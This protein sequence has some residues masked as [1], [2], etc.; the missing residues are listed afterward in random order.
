MMKNLM[1]LEPPNKASVAIQIAIKCLIQFLREANVP[2]ESILVPIKYISTLLEKTSSIKVIDNTNLKVKSKSYFECPE[3]YTKTSQPRAAQ[4]KQVCLTA[5]ERANLLAKMQTNTTLFNYDSQ[6]QAP[7]PSTQGLEATVSIAKTGQ[8]EDISTIE[9]PW[10]PL[11]AE[12]TEVAKRDKV[13]D[14]KLV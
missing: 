8:K 12:W 13:K 9:I 6:F 3:M 7:A 10:S 5:Y 2:A 14:D 1:E 4:N 11:K